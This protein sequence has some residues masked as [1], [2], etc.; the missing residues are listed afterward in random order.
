M[1]LNMTPSKRRVPPLVVAAAALGALLFVAVAARADER[2]AAPDGFQCSIT[3]CYMSSADRPFAWPHDMEVAADGRGGVG[4]YVAELRGN[5]MT[6]L[7]LPAWELAAA[8][9]EADDDTWTGGW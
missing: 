2:E 1:V 8:E 4:L 3:R 5:R 9:P 6:R 7:Q